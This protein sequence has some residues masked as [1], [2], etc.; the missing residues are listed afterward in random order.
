MMRR[1][2]FVGTLS[3]GEG[4]LELC[5][6]AVLAQQDVSVTHCVLSSMPEREA[7]DALWREWEGA[8]AHHDLFVKVDADTVLVDPWV[9]STIMSVFA[10]NAPRL[11]GMQLPIL[12]YF[13]DGPIAGLNAFSPAVEFQRSPELHCDRADIGHRVVLKC[14]HDDMSPSMLAAVANILHV[15]LPVKLP[16]PAARH[17]FAATDAQAFHFGLHRALKGQHAVID[18][19][20]RALDIHGGRAR[21]LALLG[22]DAAAGGVPPGGQDYGSVWFRAS[23]GLAV[24]VVDREMGQ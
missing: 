21:R 20:R 16:V 15:E 7:H 5:K 17:C 3:C 1:R 11:T 4:E 18:S 8:R 9:L 6:D 23:V 22:A 12:D 24:D 19:V 10:A 2:V 13:T 14:P